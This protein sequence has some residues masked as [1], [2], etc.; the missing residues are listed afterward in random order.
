MTPNFETWLAKQYTPW[1]ER[2]AKMLGSPVPTDIA[3]L[4]QEQQE[5]EPMYSDAEDFKAMAEYYAK[6]EPGIT[7][8]GKA[9][10]VWAVADTAGRCRVISSR[11]FKV[12][13]Q[14]KAQSPSRPA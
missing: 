10:V 2:S 4:Q 13:Q 11:A 14:L 5:L 6:A 9:R 8:L 12:A 7:T 1:R 3:A